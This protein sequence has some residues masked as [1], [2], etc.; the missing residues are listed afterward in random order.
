MSHSVVAN[1]VVKRIRGAL[2]L[3]E[4]SPGILATLK[5]LP[6]DIKAVNATASLFIKSLLLGIDHSLQKKERSA[7]FDD[8]IDF[9]DIED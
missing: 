2:L 3:E 5:V 8:T 4:K 6:A 9:D 1:S 7:K